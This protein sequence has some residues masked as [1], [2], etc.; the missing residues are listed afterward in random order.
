MM[1]AE[2]TDRLL[3]FAGASVHPDGGFA[4]LADDGRPQLDRPVELWIT[5]RMTHVFALAHL[6]GREY[7]AELVDHGIAALTGRFR[8][9]V[10]GGWYAAVGPDGPVARNR[11]A[12][13]HPFVVLLTA[14]TAAPGRTGAAALPADA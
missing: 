1:L 3:E 9:R 12:Y 6:M 7:A 8:D 5:C 10:H 4:W 11:T 2:E 13:E 14:E